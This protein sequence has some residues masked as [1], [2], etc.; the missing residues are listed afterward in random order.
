MMCDTY[1]V[2]AVNIS[3]ILESKLWDRKELDA[4][5]VQHKFMYRYYEYCRF[6]KIHRE[7]ETLVWH[8]EI[9]RLKPKLKLIFATRSYDK[10]GS[11]FANKED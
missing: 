6:L 10:S 1:L 2:D 9:V 4:F 11:G 3:Y 8:F 7:C 5:L